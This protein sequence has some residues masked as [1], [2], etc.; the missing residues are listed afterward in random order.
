[1]ML[2]TLFNIDDPICLYCGADCDVSSTGVGIA[3]TTLVIDQYYCQN[4][5]CKEEFEI[6]HIND[7][8]Y[9]F[10]FTCNEFRIF[11]LYE[12]NQFGVTKKEAD[13]MVK[14]GKDNYI[15]MPYFNVDFNAKEEIYRKLGVYVTFS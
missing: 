10:S 1:M 12:E 4:K 7:V 3:P 14:S 13:G 2:H 11:H 15:W 9:G 5:R 8:F 6:H